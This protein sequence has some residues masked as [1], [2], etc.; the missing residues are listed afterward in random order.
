MNEGHL[1]TARDKNDV[2]QVVT[3]VK[4]RS[5]K[6]RERKYRSGRVGWQV[7]LGEI[8]GKRIQR[9]YPTR[10]AAA[11]ALR[12]ARAARKKH[13][14]QAVKLTPAE[15]AEV[16]RLKEELESSGATLA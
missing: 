1:K 10:E 15:I 9:A 8:D 7:D 13:G 3:P 6:V 2:T 4:V 5:M 16:A 12:D 14:D 11:N